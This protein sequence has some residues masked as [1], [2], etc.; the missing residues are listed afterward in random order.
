LH[1]LLIQQ[2]KKQG[3][4]LADSASSKYFGKILATPYINIAIHPTINPIG[5]NIINNK[6]AIFA[7]EF[8]SLQ[9]LHCNAIYPEKNEPTNIPA[10]ITTSIAKLQATYTVIN[11]KHTK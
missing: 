9:N 5:M 10:I 8:P 6:N 4:S 7:H 1:F 11:K 3:K 2:K